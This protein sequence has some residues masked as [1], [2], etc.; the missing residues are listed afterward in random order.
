[1]D[2]ALALEARYYGLSQE[3]QPLEKLAKMSPLDPGALWAEEDVRRYVRRKLEAGLGKA[4]PLTRFNPETKSMINHADM[5]LVGIHASILTSPIG[6]MLAE[7]TYGKSAD[8]IEDWDDPDRIVFYHSILGVPVYCFPHV[9]AEM[10]SAYRRFQGKPQ[11]AWPLHI[12]KDWE[13][14]PDVDPDDRRREIE[15]RTEKRR[16]AVGAAALASARGLLARDADGWKLSVESGAKLKLGADLLSA[17]DAL[18][19]LETE[20]PTIY[21]LAVAPLVK[22]AAVLPDR[23]ALKAEADTALR[24]WSARAM[25]LEVL[26]KRDAEQEAEHRALREAIRVLRSITG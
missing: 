23:T 10:K 4:Q 1:M 6:E 21:D 2:Q 13:E 11:K 3:H 14:L 26:D 12:E 16:V 7:A 15:T 20:K 8:H 5:L 25:E 17:I 24:A 19:R 18:L 9:N 22:D